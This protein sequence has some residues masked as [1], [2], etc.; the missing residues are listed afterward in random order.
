M[1]PFVQIA[2]SLTPQG[3][4]I[5]LH[6]RAGDYFLRVNHQP[7]MST[8]APELAEVVCGRLSE[9]RAPRVLIGGL[10]F[11]YS[12][13][14]SLEL[15]GPKAI[16][17]VAELLPQVVEWNREFLAEVNGSLLDDARVI[18]SQGD[19]FGLIT[20][21]PPGHYD[22][23]QL[24]VDNGPVSMVQADNSRLYEA[25]GLA[26][27][28]QALKPR[29]RVAFWSAGPDQ[30]F[31]KRLIRAGFRVSEVPAKAHARARRSAHLIFVADRPG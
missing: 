1:Q 19:V 11:G 30:A 29:G 6:E 15:L 12:L 9:R 14:R 22:A 5:T 24:D 28:H 10:G 26:A 17:Q 13:R 27:I 18:V 2:H 7:L 3:A 31:A 4:V 23:I 25:Q 8:N 16:V 21:A 20:Q